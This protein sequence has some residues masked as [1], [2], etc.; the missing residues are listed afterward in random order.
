MKTF[1]AVMAVVA[2]SSCACAQTDYARERKMMVDAQVMSRGIKDRKILDA[3]GKIERHKFVSEGMRGYAY[4]DISLPVGEDEAVPPAYF[5]A[6]VAKMAGFRGG[7]RVLLIGV[8][9]GYQAAVFAELAKDVYCI[10][11]S[12][13]LAVDAQ[14]RLR[15]LGYGNIKVKVGIPQDGWLEH[16]PFDV[17]FITN[18]MD[19]APKRVVDQVM[20]NGKLI[21]PLREYWGKKLIVMTKVPKGKE[22]Y[23]MVATL[24]G[25]VIGEKP[26]DFP[27]EEEKKE[28][29]KQWVTGKDSKW[30]KRN[31]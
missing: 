12:E 18:Q 11:A 8:E 3:I 29:G 31:K 25:P 9:A 26:S 16:G 2:V 15:S 27:K 7:E 17:I 6:L 23:E 22:G 14:E 1:I 10:D 20:M 13:K 21:M 30:M 5:T 28:D 24:V 4:E 19:Y